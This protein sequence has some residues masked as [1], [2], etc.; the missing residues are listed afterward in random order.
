MSSPE[1][2]FRQTIS[3]SL[4]RTADKAVVLPPIQGGKQRRAGWFVSIKVYLPEFV[5]VETLNRFE[6]PLEH[7][8]KA[9][10]VLSY[11]LG[12]SSPMLSDGAR[13]IVDD[14]V[15][16]GVVCHADG[17]WSIDG[18]PRPLRF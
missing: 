4:A 18:E 9:Y 8:V 13:E 15:P 2:L 12:G 17:T 3:P 5:F 16:E 11:L 6:A 1:S 14:E 7:L 10:C